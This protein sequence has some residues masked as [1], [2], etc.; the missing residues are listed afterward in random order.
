MNSTGMIKRVKTLLGNDPRATDE[1]VT[2]YLDA[3]GDTIMS[4][5]H[6]LGVPETGASVPLKYHALQCE[7][8]ARYFAKQGGLGE[9]LHIE[10]GVHRHWS[11]A[12]DRDLLDRITP[13]GKV[14]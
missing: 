7:L 10:N 3:A 12:D 1:I 4:V 9:E 13:I 5:R 11:S 6:P 2:E 8:A 14:M